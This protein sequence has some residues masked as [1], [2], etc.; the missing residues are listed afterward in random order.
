MMRPSSLQAHPWHRVGSFR[1]PRDAAFLLCALLASAAARGAERDANAHQ[2]SARGL[3]EGPL[4]SL[5]LRVEVG[6]TLDLVAPGASR[7]A[8]WGK[9]GP[10]LAPLG[11][12]CL[13]DANV[14]RQL[15]RSGDWSAGRLVA[16]FEGGAR[17]T[18]HASLMS[19]GIVVEASTDRLRLFAGRHERLVS[20]DNRGR[21]K[22]LGFPNQPAPTG[23]VAPA[24]AAVPKGRAV[25]A[26]AIADAAPT[27]PADDAWM[28]VYW[29]D[30][31]HFAR[32]D[33]P[34][35]GQ[36]F[37]RDAQ[38]A[39]CPLLLVFAAAPKSVR[40]AK[41]GGLDFTFAGAA[42][43]VVLPIAAAPMPASATQAWREAIPDD[44]AATCR[45]LAAFARQYPISARRAFHYDAARDEAAF[46]ETFRFAPVGEGGRKLAP[47]PPMVAVA[48]RGGMAIDA[49]TKLTDLPAA[50]QFGPASGAEGRDSVSWTVKGLSRYVELPRRRPP[51][52][53]ARELQAELSQQV[54]RLLEAGRLLPWSYA[55]NVPI[56]DSRGELYWAEP[57]E[58]LY[59]LV[60][61]CPLLGEAQAA[62]LADYMSGLREFYPPEKVP[63]MPIDRG[64]PRGGYD[65]GASKAGKAIARERGGRVSVFALYGLERCVALTGRKPD[66]ASWQACRKLLADA[67]VEQGWATL[68]LLGHGDRRLPWARDK[69]EGA[70]TSQW[71]GDRPAA[72]VNANRMFAGAVGAVRL[73]RLMNDAEAEQLA[74]RLLARAAVLRC[75]MGKLPAWRIAAG[76]AKLP[77]DPTWQWRIESGSWG[78]CLETPHWSRPEHDVR[79]VVELGQDGPRLDDFA[80]TGG[81]LWQQ[82]VTAQ[83]VAFRYLTP[84]LAAFLRDHLKAETAELVRRIE[85]NL[86]HWY[87]S[88]SEAILGWEHSMNHPSDAFQV[89]LARAW[90]LE[91]GPQ[92]LVRWL[93]VPWLARGDLFYMNKLAETIRAHR[94]EAAEPK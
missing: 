11:T 65:P 13:P 72:V 78:G 41:E 93:D 61:L 25:E 63:L 86:P 14:P 60:G 88:F 23:P 37:Q 69:Q 9:V 57:G 76:L 68:Y 44:V 56:N 91:E 12:I 38:K 2:S 7:D 75:A 21:L 43:L 19:P 16:T 55:D 90:V 39:D 29:A 66:A 79:Q 84:E 51:A 64:K 32:S 71:R 83:L 20:A 59:L 46:T 70:P 27:P 85:L 1:G 52:G 8:G 42:R 35:A 33:W 15:E 87:A 82:R 92:R 67:F 40:P 26:A 6:R 81:D 22:V 4:C 28:L 30:K 80:G 54:A 48:M 62:R 3:T 77:E 50:T 34:L 73:A 10:S 36:G 89:F 58:A 47:L 31:T 18:L 74:W 24:F 53:A 49:S 94:G 5:V 17:L 45:R